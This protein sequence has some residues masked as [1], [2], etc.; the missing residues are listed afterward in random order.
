MSFSDDMLFA[1]KA[2][3]Q[4]EP[5]AQ[6]LL[7]TW[8]LG[9]KDYSS[10]AKW[11]Q[12]AA[13]QG[14]ADAQLRLGLQYYSGQGV[15]EDKAKGLEWIRKAAEQGYARAQFHMGHHSNDDAKAVEWFRKAA[16]QGDTDAQYELN[17]LENKEKD[18]KEREERERKEREEK[19]VFDSLFTSAEQGDANAQ[20]KLGVKY[21]SGKGAPENNIEAT[22]WLN[23]AASQGNI[24]AAIFITQNSNIK[25]D[26]KAKDLIKKAAKQGNEDAKIFLAKKNKEKTRDIIRWI[27]IGIISVFFGMIG[28]AYGS[29]IVPATIILSIIY[30]IICIINGLICER[31]IGSIQFGAICFALPIGIIGAVFGGGFFGWL[32]FGAF[33]GAISG[34]LIGLANLLKN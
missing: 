9:Q 34:L 1:L 15:T 13:E 17:I 21:F 6:N 2:A 11:F 31:I 5:V 26:V 33:I 19:E 14:Y 12:K 27:I 20:Y 4:G 30:V 23:K 32:F 8:Y 25:D 18:R 24:K 10:A 3:E 22:K 28:F 7:G 16:S 29:D